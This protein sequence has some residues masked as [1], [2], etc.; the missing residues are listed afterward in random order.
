ML[1]EI[2]DRE[3]IKKSMEL[4]GKEQKTYTLFSGSPPP[5]VTVPKQEEVPHVSIFHCSGNRP[6]VSFSS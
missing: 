6:E 3:H 4:K 5:L 2:G 1:K